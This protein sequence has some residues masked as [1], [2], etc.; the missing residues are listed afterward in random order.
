MD[1]TQTIKLTSSEMGCLWIN[2]M[3]D[4]MASYVLSYFLE[5]SQDPEARSILEYACGLSKAHLQTIS[6]IFTKENFPIPHGFTQADVNVD[7]P[8]L[9]SDP[10][11]LMYLKNMSTLGL[12]AYSLALSQAT[13]DDIREYFKECLN[14]SAEL[15]D[16]VVGTMLSKGLLVRP[17]SISVPEKVKFVERQRFL[18]NLLGAGNERPLIAIEIT[19]LF[20]NIEATI[21]VRALLIAFSQVCQSKKVRDSMIRGRDIATKH[22]DLFAKTLQKNFLPAPMPSDTNVSDSKIAPFSDKLMMFHATLLASSGTG[23]YGLAM[24]ASPRKDIVADYARLMTELA[25]YTEDGANIMI[26]NGWL[27]EP[28]QADDRT[29]LARG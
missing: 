13:R 17:P 22:I 16:K 21:T 1:S 2:Y 4:S 23:N 10:F 11:Y 27:E 29:A 28:P 5:K 24:A 25:Q 20:T 19:H 26:E 12:A 18:S 9:F 3:S 6:N 14:Q 8:P 15:Y 7:A